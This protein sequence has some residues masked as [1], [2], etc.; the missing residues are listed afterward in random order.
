MDQKKDNGF[1]HA[2]LL[3]LIFIA[4]IL[5]NLDCQKSVLEGGFCH[6]AVRSFFLSSEIP[7]SF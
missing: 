7:V 5:V 6:T 2:T 3:T 4:T 1:P